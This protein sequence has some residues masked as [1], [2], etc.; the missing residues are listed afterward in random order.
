MERRMEDIV[1]SL[2][3]GTSCS[4]TETSLL[5]K[6]N[7]KHLLSKKEDPSKRV[8]GVIS[9]SV[10]EEL[11]MLCA[12]NLK[13]RAPNDHSL[14]LWACMRNMNMHVFATRYLYSSDKSSFRYSVEYTATMVHTL[15]TSLRTR[16]SYYMLE[17][18]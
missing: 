11:D 10:A 18:T 6:I 7:H 4:L 16:T 1:A 15:N 8:V 5:Y 17:L 13:A 12:Q 9:S 3:V 2:L 14:E